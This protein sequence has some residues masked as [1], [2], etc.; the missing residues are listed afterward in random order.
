[1]IDSRHPRV[2][3]TATLST[4]D[5]LAAQFSED[6]LRA[7]LKASSDVVLLFD[8]DGRYLKVAESSRKLLYCPDEAL[9]GRTV[10]EVL[11]KSIADCCLERI[12]E[13]LHEKRQIQFDY[14]MPLAS[15][16]RYF[17]CTVYPLPNRQ[18]VLWFARD[19][20][21]HRAADLALAARYDMERLISRLS[22]QFINVEPRHIDAVIDQ[23]LGEM[24]RYFAVDRA[25]IYRLSENGSH[26]L[27]THGWRKDTIRSRLG[28]RK[29]IPNENFP[30]LMSRLQAQE[31]IRISAVEQLPAEAES[32]RQTFLDRDANAIVIVPIVFSGSL[33][34]FIGFDANASSREWTDGEVHFLKNAGELF[35]SALQ[36]KQ[37]E[38]K[39]R[40]LAFYDDLTGLP[41]RTQLRRQLKADIDQSG[42]PFVLVLLDL[43]DSSAVNDLLGHDVGDQLLRTLSDRL[44]RFLGDRHTLGRWGGDEFLLTLPIEAGTEEFMPLAR[45][46]QEELV[47]PVIINE[48]ELRVSCC[49]GIARYPDDAEDVD[50]LIRFGEMALHEAKQAG[51]GSLRRY[52]R[53]LK[54]TAARHNLLR[55]RLRRAVDHGE[56]TLHYQPLVDCQSGR[57]IGAEALLRWFDTEL[58]TIGP[59]QFIPIAEES[60][61]IA[62]LGE[63]VLDT[64][65]AELR[66]WHNPLGTLPRISINV[67]GLQLLDHRLANALDRVIAAQGLQATQIELEITESALMER[68]AAGLPLLQHLR[69]L[70][71]GIA[72]DDF[73]TGYSSLAKI[74]HMPVNVLKIDRSFIQD[75]FTDSDDKA[76]VIAILALAKQLQLKVVAEGVETEQQLQFLQEAGCDLIQGY[77]FSKPLPAKD[78]R[79]L[80]AK[81]VADR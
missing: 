15:G 55:G 51:R 53:K 73:G 41:N 26:M 33:D 50:S 13:A 61:L 75:I 29:P 17:S 39:I 81:G 42:A 20:S 24:G 7:L 4:L 28:Y 49:T 69:E 6:E 67:S 68:E 2:D 9:T 60:G 45:R 18:T 80:W 48:Q 56:F 65:C 10:H 57:I 58:G 64:A 27:N 59:D 37:S 11:P 38:E 14:S 31:I 30:W 22:S 74:K 63:W 72:V 71:V 1:M 40:Q 35:A 52:T 16:K 76:I 44:K 34:G 70:G 66:H 19:I 3:E 78:F 54:E 5:S 12:R 25:Y 43:D 46:I 62:P 36:R 32:E 79:K 47:K 21:A 8:A 23:A 77:I